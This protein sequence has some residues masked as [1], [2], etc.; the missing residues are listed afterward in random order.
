MH[1]EGLGLFVKLPSRE[2]E[3]HVGILPRVSN[4]D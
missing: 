2:L 3:P 1:G 4:K